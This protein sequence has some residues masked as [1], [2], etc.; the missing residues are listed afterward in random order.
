MARDYGLPILEREDMASLTDL[1]YGKR[2]T[3]IRINEAG[4][5]AFL[6]QFSR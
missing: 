1:I 5:Q 3:K 2:E 6:K 4:I